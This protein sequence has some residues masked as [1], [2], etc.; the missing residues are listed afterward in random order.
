MYFPDNFGEGPDPGRFSGSAASTPK[1]WKQKIRLVKFESLLIKWYFKK[2]LPLFGVQSP[3]S[4]FGQK[5]DLK[6]CH[7]QGDQLN[8]AVCFWYLVKHD[9]FSVHNVYSSVHWTSNYY[10]VL[11]KHGHV[12]LVGLY[13]CRGWNLLVPG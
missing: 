8:K 3:G 1:V 2:N 11:K 9:L 6:H 10:K 7:I 4:G 5:L 12:Y 13:R